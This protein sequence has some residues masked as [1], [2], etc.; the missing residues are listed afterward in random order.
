VGI[1]HDKAYI[2]PISLPGI[3]ILCLLLPLLISC[4][5]EKPATY[6][7]EYSS[8]PAVR[9][10]KY[11]LGVYPLHNPQLLEYIYGPI[12]DYLNRRL[13]GPEIK[14]EASLSYEEFDKKLY[15]RH[16][17]FALSNPYQ[18]INSLRHGYRVFGKMGA[19]EEFRG[20]ILVRKDSGINDVTDLR[21][22]S[23]SF[24]APTALETTM[25][26]LYFLHTSG[27]DVNRDIARLFSG[28]HDSAILNVYLRTSAAGATC[29][30]SWKAFKERYPEIAAELAVKW[31][32]PQLINNGLV[33]RDDVPAELTARVARLLFTMNDNEEGRRLLAALPLK[34]FEPATPETYTPVYAFMERYNKVIR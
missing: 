20:I 3:F 5:S 12:V 30:S 23:I 25:L 4:D 18:T 11:V 8:Q 6:A 34:R 19:D 15:S 17:H 29:P 1:T 32:T 13:S 2:W 16:F 26:P 22:K 31:E 21:G 7:P 9:Q 14:L 33:S 10:N 28:S 24:P 27:L